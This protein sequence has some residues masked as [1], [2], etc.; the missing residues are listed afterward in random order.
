MVVRL[1]GVLRL[2]LSREPYQYSHVSRLTCSTSP[3][4]SENLTSSHNMSSQTFPLLSLIDELLLQ[5]ISHVNDV[6]TLLNLSCTCKKLRDFSEPELLR[7]ILILYPAKCNQFT[8]RLKADPS[9]ARHVH[10]YAVCVGHLYREYSGMEF[11][12]LLEMRNLESLK[13][14]SPF[15]NTGG[16]STQTSM[17]C[18]HREKQQF[19]DAFEHASI[20][21]SP[22]EGPKPF[23]RL[24][25]CKSHRVRMTSKNLLND[26]SSD[27]PLDFGW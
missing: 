6:S 10:N 24:K 9:S 20:V 3:D 15:G 23:Q 1:H 12:D 18:W 16:Y 7:N 5:V 11:P 14:E 2:P 21:S 4:I 27:T 13:L 17:D 26:K 19:L 25:L 8:R 22:S